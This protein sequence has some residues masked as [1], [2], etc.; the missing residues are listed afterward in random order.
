MVHTCHL[1]YAGITNRRV[2]IQVSHGIK[3]NPVSKI[4]KAK[5]A[6]RITQMVQCLPSKYEALSSINK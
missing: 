5:K 1:I 6:Y 2:T 3:Y 4:I